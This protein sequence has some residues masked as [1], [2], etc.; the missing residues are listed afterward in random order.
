M[1]N[2]TIKM[3]EDNIDNES[4]EIEMTDQSVN[5]QIHSDITRRLRKTEKAL[6]KLKTSVY[7][8]NREHEKHDFVV[9]IVDERANLRNDLLPP[10]AR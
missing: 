10:N 8:M 4:L 6:K 3:T 1:N 7:F 9:N 2:I 5:N